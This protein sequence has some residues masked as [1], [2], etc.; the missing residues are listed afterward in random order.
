MTKGFNNL[1]A[2]PPRRIV[3]LRAL[4][5]GDLL[6]SVPV[7]R[8]LRGAWPDAEIVLVGLPW[9]KGFVE[10][11]SCY[12]DDFCEFPGYPGLPECTPQLARIP[13]FLLELQAE[14]FDLAI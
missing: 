9:A 11:Y 7:F 13:R 8:A 12:L 3:V 2:A 1:R 4:K 5:L 6:C 14:H 10:R